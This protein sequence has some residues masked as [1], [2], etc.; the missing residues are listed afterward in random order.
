MRV[1]VHIRVF[2][3][4]RVNKFVREMKHNLDAILHAKGNVRETLSPPSTFP[5]LCAPLPYIHAEETHT[6]RGGSWD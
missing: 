1:T 4:P 6:L 3:S 2:F 5:L